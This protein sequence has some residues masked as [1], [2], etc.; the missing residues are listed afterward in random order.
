L[1]A[2][3]ANHIFGLSTQGT[4]YPSELVELHLP[5]PHVSDADLRL[6]KALELPTM[7]VENMVLIQ[8][9]TLVILHSQIDHVF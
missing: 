4:G 1:H 7:C 2:A 3:G 8:R 9:L 5:F 6:S